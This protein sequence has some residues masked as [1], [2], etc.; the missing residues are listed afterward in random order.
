MPLIHD[1]ITSHCT[2]E[3][4]HLLQKFNEHSEMFW[5]SLLLIIIT[6]QFGVLYSALLWHHFPATLVSKDRVESTAL[7]K[8]CSIS[9][10][11][12]VGS[13]GH[14][15]C[16]TRPLET[17]F[18]CEY[19]KLWYASNHMGRDS[20]SCLLASGILT[21]FYHLCIT[22]LFLNNCFTTVLWKFF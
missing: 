3:G 14:F 12:T 16:F 9:A 11:Q 10:F 17:G 15:R 5:S 2:L 4:N 22:Y 19:C 20:N 21:L 8:G 1:E 7:P 13:T 18:K 6:I